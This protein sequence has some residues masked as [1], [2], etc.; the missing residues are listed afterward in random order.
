MAFLLAGKAAQFGWGQ[1]KKR[2]ERKAA[3]EHPWSPPQDAPYQMSGYPQGMAPGTETTFPSHKEEQSKGSKLMGMLISATRFFQFAFGLAVIGL[4]GQDV[5]HDHQDKH[6]WHAK[7]VFALITAFVATVTSAVYLAVQLL[8]RGNSNVGSNPALHLPRFV[9]EFVLCVLW[10]TLFG[11]FGKMYIGVYPSDKK[12][13][14]KNAG[15]GDASKI[16][17][18]RHAVWVDLINLIMWATTSSF[19]L[20]RWLK[21][22]RASGGSVRDVEKEEGQ[23][24]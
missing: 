17:R 10:L 21:G 13:D 15:L 5:R 19:V 2:K 4:Y 18:M 6:T 24:F 23:A 11:I 16:N 7:W 9:W 22:R 14:E 12:D 1:Y 20:L 3:Q 8:R